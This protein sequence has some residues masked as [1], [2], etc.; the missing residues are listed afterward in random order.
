M[1]RPRARSE[2]RLVAKPKE[3]FDAPAF[4]R[5]R[6]P[7]ERHDVR[8]TLSKI[9]GAYRFDDQQP[10]TRFPA[11]ARFFGGL[12]SGQ[13]AAARREAYNRL[14]AALPQNPSFLRGLEPGDTLAQA[15]ARE[16]RKFLFA[17]RGNPNRRDQRNWLERAWAERRERLAKRARAATV[18]ARAVGPWLWRPGGRLA[19]MD[20]E[21]ALA[22]LSTE[23]AQHAPQPDL[24]PPPPP[25]GD[26][27]TLVRSRLARKL[28]C[29]MRDW[30]DIKFMNEMYF[31]VL[32]RANRIDD[33]LLELILEWKHADR[34]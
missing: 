29:D 23:R 32:L 24:E 9:E 19:V 22:L 14:A 18:I 21:R 17:T 8:L 11:L 1:Q 28:K 30:R 27:P 12:L 13:E 16:L 26:T 5:R 3:S 31:D 20:G 33:R 6:R 15:E 10:L 25:F 4:G 34:G 2:P 7:S